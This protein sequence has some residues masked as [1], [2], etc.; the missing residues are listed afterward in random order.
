MS[1]EF[2]DIALTR[3]CHNNTILFENT[4]QFVSEGISAVSGHR[5]FRDLLVQNDT[6]SQSVQESKSVLK[7]FS[8]WFLRERSLR[9]IILGNSE[10]KTQYIRYKN[11][12]MLHFIDKP[13]DWN[14]NFKI[15]AQP[16][17]VRKPIQK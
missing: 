8:K 14:A 6:D 16:F 1:N 17:R 3:F 4:L 9:F 12:V 11:Q 5:T 13:Q 15:K 7:S 10:K 2:K